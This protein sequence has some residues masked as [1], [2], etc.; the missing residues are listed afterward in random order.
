MIYYDK[1]LF[2]SCST[3]SILIINQPPTFHLNPLQ[4][5]EFCQCR[6][7]Q[8]TIVLSHCGNQL[9][10]I[11]LSILLMMTNTYP[12]TWS[13]KIEGLC[14]YQCICTYCSMLFDLHHLSMYQNYHRLPNKLFSSYHPPILSRRQS[15]PCKISNCRDEC[16]CDGLNRVSRAEA[17]RVLLD[18]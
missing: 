3:I 4:W 17:E 15:A 8:A 13:P 18:D 10:S 2:F 9:Y 14:L 12:C 6:K 7:G 11:F 16:G 1:S 5:G